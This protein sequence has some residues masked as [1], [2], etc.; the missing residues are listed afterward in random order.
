MGTC[1]SAWRALARRC[2]GAQGRRTVALAERPVPAAADPLVGRERLITQILS[3]IH[4]NSILLRGEE[5]I[6]KTAILLELERRLIAIDD[7]SYEFFP[8]YVDLQGVAESKLFGTLAEAIGSRLAPTAQAGRDG[9]WD[10]T[11]S[12]GH[13]DLV[14][15]LR[16]VLRSLGETRTQQV[17]LVLLIDGIDALEGYHPRTAQRL[18]GL[19]M[20]NLTDSLVMVATAVEI[21]RR[22]DRE[23]SPWYNF[24]EEIELEPRRP[25]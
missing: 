4:N 8:V 19:F 17:R 2:A 15:E 25:G 21:S 11:A 16:R 12:F 6:G 9:A 18:R 1:R 5:G 23:G 7:P 13:R 14:L 3:T 20:T 10:A 24:F 22:W